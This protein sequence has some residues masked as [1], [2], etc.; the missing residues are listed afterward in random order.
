VNSVLGEEKENTIQ[1]LLLVFFS[2]SE[3]TLKEALKQTVGIF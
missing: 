1:P 3:F 2:P